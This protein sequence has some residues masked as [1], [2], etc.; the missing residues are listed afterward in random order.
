VPSTSRGS[1]RCTGR[2]SGWARARVDREPARDVPRGALRRELRPPRHPPG[3]RHLGH[4]ARVRR[5]VANGAGAAHRP[6]LPRHDAAALSL[7]DVCV[8]GDQVRSTAMDWPPRSSTARRSPPVRGTVRSGPGWPSGCG[9]RRAPKRASR[10][11]SA[12][13]RVPPRASPRCSSVGRGPSSVAEASRIQR[14]A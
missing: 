11:A 7:A 1:L 5:A 4:P 14:V 9:R 12:Q 2:P 8:P 3:V 10:L 13:P 6:A